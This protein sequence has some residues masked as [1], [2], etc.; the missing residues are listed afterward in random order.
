MLI[1]LVFQERTFLRCKCFKKKL[2][3]KLSNNVNLVISIN[4]FYLDAI[5]DT[6]FERNVSGNSSDVTLTEKESVAKQQKKGEQKNLTWISETEEEVCTKQTEQ[7]HANER[8]SGTGFIEEEVC[9]EH[10]YNSG[11]SI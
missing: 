3:A 11:C 7:Q 9:A 8:N 6:F 4:L 1:H 10:N 2:A 5:D